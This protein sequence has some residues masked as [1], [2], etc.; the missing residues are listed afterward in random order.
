MWRNSKNKP[1]LDL[2]E[3]TSNV[4][5]VKNGNDQIT[6][7]PNQVDSNDEGKLHFYFLQIL[8]FYVFCSAIA[9]SQFYDKY[10]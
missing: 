8:S 7:R 5:I 3:T 10:W 6:S 9:F 1:K 4:E 2:I